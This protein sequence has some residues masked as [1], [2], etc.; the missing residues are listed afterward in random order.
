MRSV[1]A[2]VPKRLTSDVGERT[3]DNGAGQMTDLKVTYRGSDMVEVTNDVA[4]TSWTFHISTDRSGRRH[5]EG[6]HGSTEAM[7]HSDLMRHA[8]VFAQSEALHAG[9][10]DY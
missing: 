4:G 1:P 10:I 3:D 9:K 2:S 8:C 5:L 6:P 7:A